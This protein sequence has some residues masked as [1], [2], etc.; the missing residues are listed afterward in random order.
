ME[1]IHDWRSFQHTF[2]PLKKNQVLPDSSAAPAYLVVE[3]ERVV[4]AYA[5]S[6]SL[7]HWAGATLTDVRDQNPSRPLVVYGREAVDKLMSD[8]LALPHF[9][10]QLE[11]LRA[12]AKPSEGVLPPF[13][14]HFLLDSLLGWWSKVLPSS[15]GLFIRVETDGKSQEQDFVLIVRRGSLEGFLQPDL[16]SLGSQ[17]RK[18]GSDVVKYLSEK[19]LVP[20]QGIF[21]SPQEW[22]QWAYQADPW[23]EVARSIKA[24]RTRLVPFRWTVAFL[25]TTRG[26][27]KV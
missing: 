17:R 23:R 3:N 19:Y 13:R 20:F 27:L 2:Y 26:F 21:V 1:L 6:E 7:A 15:Y 24:N 14:R 5:D 12:H 18:Q 25:A 10:H 8:S 11:Y 4:S 9:Y 22:N 16:A